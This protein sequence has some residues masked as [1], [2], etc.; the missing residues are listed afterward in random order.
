MYLPTTRQ[1]CLKLGWSSLDVI[2]VSGDSYIDSPYI[3]TAVIGKYLVKYGFRVGIISQP[4]IDSDSDI[5]RLGEPNLYWGVSAGCVDSMVA[6]YTALNIP[7]KS[8]D[9]TPG[10]INNKRPDRA[11]LVYTNLIRKNF[12][13][14][15]PIVLGGI[16]A[17]LR[18]VAHY[19]YK[20]DKIR[21]SILIDS[22]ADA[23]IY[24]MGERASLELAQD[25]KS[26]KDWRGIR[27]LSHAISE[28]EMGGLLSEEIKS[29]GKIKIGDKNYISIPSYEQ[30][31]ENKESFIEMY[32]H[33][34][35][36]N[37]PKTAKG[38]IQKHGNR[39]VIQNPPAFYLADEELDEV[40][41]LD[42][43]RN[44]HPD[45]LKKG[46]I[47][48]L[49]TIQFSLTTH[50]GCFGECNFCAIAVHQG[51]TIRS[52][53]KKSILEEANMIAKHKDFKGTIADVGG[54]TA[55]MYATECSK[56]TGHKPCK[57]KRCIFPKT[58]SESIP[59][60]KKQINLLEK[61]R[62]ID[63]VKKVFIASGIR[64][65]LISEDKKHG[66]K[67]IETICEHHVSG[68]LKLAPEHT[69]KNVLK[70][71]GKP[72]LKSTLEF[73]KHFD[74]TS[75]KLNK[76]QFLTYYLIAAHPGCS[77][78]DMEKMKGTIGRELR[79]SPEQV[80][81]FTPTPGTWASVMYHTGKDPFSGEEIFIE[82]GHS[83]KVKQKE[84]L[85]PKNRH[86]GKQKIIRNGK[87]KFKK[88]K[89]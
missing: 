53:S 44:A 59:N 3:G 10:G 48:A 57:N 75:S 47:K 7:R 23:I 19:D 61:I 84:V 76:K 71:M 6:N 20:T 14:T 26:G 9:Y 4:D 69:E 70:Q 50:R 77:L 64:P 40:Y 72:N 2:L 16:E 63:G 67:Y 89:R 25:L 79:I 87:K 36:N 1:E 60:H 12:K 24:G 85:I 49:D 56:H 54:P 39:Y 74:K 32:R 41:N 28:K 83:G 21:R 62:N 68:Q 37:T 45:E 34:Y 55:N 86:S 58:C 30:V 65:D 51:R 35:N 27:G 38:L 80:Q 18:R 31:A 8:D 66:K 29:D 78:S 88:K 73:K 33:F 22:K 43:E 52:R 11:S 42:Y 17:S 13:N 5:T 15:V 82:K 81:I 46:K